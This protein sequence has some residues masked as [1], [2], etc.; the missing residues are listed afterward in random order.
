MNKGNRVTVLRI[1][2]IEI[3]SKNCPL[4]QNCCSEAK[5]TSHEYSVIKNLICPVIFIQ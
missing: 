1:I 4:V 5:N 2:H 3:Y